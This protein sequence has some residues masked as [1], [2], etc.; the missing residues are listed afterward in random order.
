MG[1]E[2]PSTSEEAFEATV[3]GAYYAEQFRQ[4]RANGQITRV[5]Y[6]PNLPV[7]T[8]WDIGVR[9]YTSIW[10]AQFCVALVK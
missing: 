8:A 6:D 7:V 2:F 9:D 4:I 1:Q 10:F 3:L 5:P